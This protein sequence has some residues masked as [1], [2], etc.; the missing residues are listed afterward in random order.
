MKTNLSYTF[1]RLLFG[2]YVVWY[3]VVSVHETHKTENV[4]LIT[5]SIHEFANFTE[6][7]S[8]SL[9]STYSPYIDLSVLSQH[10]SDILTFMSLLFIVGGFICISGYSSAFHF[11]MLGLILDMFFIH[12]YAYFKYE[13]MKVNVLKLLSILGGA[14]FII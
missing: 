5:K 7:I 11:I 14:Y 6:I 12:N 10:S 8:P 1:I 9:L 4:L 2:L 3:G 13:K